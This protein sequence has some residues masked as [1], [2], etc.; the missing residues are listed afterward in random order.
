MV[1][2]A[3]LDELSSLLGAGG[4]LTGDD[5]ASRGAGVWRSDGIAASAILRPRDTGQ[6]AACLRL[7]HDRGQPLVTLGGLTGLV[8]GALTRPGELG[9]SME[10]MHEI[11][12]IDTHGR[13][14]TVQAGVPLAALQDAVAAKGLQ[15]PLDLGARGSCTIG[16]NLATNAGGN[17]VLR[18]GM[19]RVQ[20][21]GL[22]A[23]LADGTVISS[24]NRML[25]NNAGYDLK[26][27]F[28]GTEGTLGVIT[29]AVL[30]LH[31]A[32][33]SHQVAMV[34]CT[35]FD[36]LTRLLGTLDGDFAGTL[37]AFEVMWPEFYR[38]VTT[39][40]A[41]GRPPLGDYPVY[42]LLDTLGAH[43]DLDQQRFEQVLGE[44][45]ES[46]L[47][48]DA[49]IARSDKERAGLWALRD[50]VEQV[51]QWG[52]A[53]IFD[54]SLPIDAMDGYREQVMAAWRSAYPD[55]HFLVF[56]HLGDGNLHF[57][58]SVGEDSPQARECIET[59]LYQPLTALGGS[60]SAEHGI[61]L[62]KKRWLASCRTA[63]EIALMKSLKQA[64]DPA[65]ILNPGKIFDT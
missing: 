65:G 36:E 58:A 15:F 40:P 46:G 8:E 19:T 21:L 3:L 44:Q 10:R 51:F 13:T 6:V 9:L 59:A 7:C 34:A 64:L 61:G 11:E 42:V 16:G 23:V 31:T 30:R 27:L 20:V 29:R 24:M 4:V 12:A 55:G 38:M 50:D 47:I 48:A 2:A 39:P 14:A 56:G 41:S 32:P 45:L 22:E 37:S 28:I 63:T 49:V 35:G 54:V 43:P 60:V 17:R 62:E 5:V 25:K 18:Y 33:R 52:P 26:Q 1:E 53:M 57:S